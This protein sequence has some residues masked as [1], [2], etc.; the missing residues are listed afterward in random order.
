MMDAVLVS[1]PLC[2]HE[3]STLSF[4]HRI[5]AEAGAMY[6]YWAEDAGVAE[7]STDG[8]ASW[9]I[10]TPIP[11]YNARAS[12]SNSIFLDSYERCWSGAFDWQEAVFDLSAWHGPVLLRLRFAS[13][14]QYGF[15][16]WF[17]DDIRVTTEQPTG[18][19]LPPSAAWVTN[20]LPAVPNPFN[21][22]TTVSFELASRTRIDLDIYDVAGR[23]IRR[24]ISGVRNAGRHRVSW[25][26]IDDHGRP[27]ASGVY[28]CRLRAGAYEATG[29]LVL[30]R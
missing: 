18:T 21:P 2:L 30:V 28:F 5:G 12:A 1:P 4:H 3:N 23:K 20:L 15:E 16:G 6:P 24:L 27:V 8:G 26:G 25:N 9:T 22:A 10:L 19:D 11:G 7:I 17:V 13:N 14:E 29:R